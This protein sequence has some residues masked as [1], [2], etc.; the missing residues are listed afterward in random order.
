[1]QYSTLSRCCICSNICSFVKSL[2]MSLLHCLILC[3][4][5][6][7]IHYSIHI[8]SQN[9]IL[10]QIQGLDP[11][12]TYKISLT[13]PSGFVIIVLQWST[14]ACASTLLVRSWNSWFTNPSEV[15]NDVKNTFTL[16]REVAEILNA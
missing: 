10:S 11:P 6:L 2:K 3:V 4:Q 5:L 9:T 1:M 7:P 12:T 16:S 15:P 13:L 8:H 14:V